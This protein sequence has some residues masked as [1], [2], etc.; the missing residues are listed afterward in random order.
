[1][2]HENKNKI[3]KTNEKYKKD[4]KYVIFYISD[5]VV[6][7]LRCRKPFK[8]HFVHKRCALLQANMKF[9]QIYF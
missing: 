5:C 6:D 8:F 4:F 1:M 2:Y 7:T 3:R 9:N